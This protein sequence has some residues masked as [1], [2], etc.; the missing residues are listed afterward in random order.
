[1]LIN[2]FL[3]K[4][5]LYGLLISVLVVPAQSATLSYSP[6]AFFPLPD[7]NDNRVA[8]YAFDATTVDQEKPRINDFTDEA[9]IVVVFEGTLWELAYPELYGSDDAY[10]LNINGGP[11]STYNQIL[12][13]IQS[14][15]QRGVKVLMN[16]D[17][18]PSWS[19]A[20]PFTTWDGHDLDAQGFASFVYDCA[21]KAGF[22][23]IS[24]D[25]E[26][27]ASDNGYYRNLI[28]ELGRY[29]GP[30]SM[31]PDTMIYTGAFYSGGA[32]GPSFR[33]PQ[34]SQYLNF[35]MDM[36]YFQND[37]SRF[38]YWA[39]SLGNEKVMI[40]FSHQMNDLERAMDHAFWHPNPDKAGVM[41]FAGNVNKNYTDS[42][43]AAL[44]DQ[45][46]ATKLTPYVNV[47]DRGWFQTNSGYVSAGGKVVLG[48]GPN[49]G[50]WSWSGPNGYRA[51]QREITLN[52]ISASQQ[53]TYVAT[54][55]NSCGTES[56]V[57]FYVQVN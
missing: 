22:D 9:N 29:F 41:V 57:T 53:G 45:C 32:P 10:I 14:L 36:G 35:V 13:D 43:F 6:E 39:N 7:P 34:L 15:R 56:T 48:P 1:M 20:T 5:T 46:P 30:L 54:N 25:V 21:L 4:I 2:Q 16:V 24:L 55:L 42:I 18:R 52:N 19:T 44:Q 8:Y 31:N 50:T 23:G 51:Y 49:S 40:G 3:K 17:D 47:N 37:S 26:H 33:D 28:R 11:Y 12:D 38:N 27:G